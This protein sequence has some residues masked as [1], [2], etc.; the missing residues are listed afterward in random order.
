MKIRIVKKSELYIPQQYAKTYYSHSWKG[1]GTPNIKF[2]NEKDARE[3]VNVI[4]RAVK[5]TN[6]ADSAKVVY[7]NFQE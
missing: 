2:E 6:K 3:F 7:K 4:G 1:F 5:T